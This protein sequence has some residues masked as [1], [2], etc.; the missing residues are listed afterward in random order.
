MLFRKLILAAA[1]TAPALALADGPKAYQ[2]EAPAARVKAGAKGKA[3]IHIQVKAG[4]HVSEE[5]PL[6]IALKSDGLKLDKELLRTPDIV[7]GKGA[8]PRFE[9][10]F[11]AAKPGAQSIE[12]TMNFVVCTKEL[13]ERES[14]TVKIPVSVE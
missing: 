1:L 10:P 2:V 3:T 7:E 6:K 11:T 4:S 8:S 13:C 14:E 12:A 5:A 9:V